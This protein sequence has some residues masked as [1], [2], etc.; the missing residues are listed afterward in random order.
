MTDAVAAGDLAEYIGRDRVLRG[1][2]C[3]VSCLTA[4]R[5]RTVWRYGDVFVVRYVLP[6]NLK[7][8]GGGGDR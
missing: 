3:E 5:V 8:L 4:L 1:Q 6:A 2:R 7:K